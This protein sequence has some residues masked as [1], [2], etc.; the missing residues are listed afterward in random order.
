[1]NSTKYLTAASGAFLLVAI[2]FSAN[3][4]FAQEQ[5]VTTATP[6]IESADSV[7]PEVSETSTEVSRDE[8]PA[9]TESENAAKVA[10]LEKTE[11]PAREQSA[12]VLD[13]G[14][15]VRFGKR[16]SVGAKDDA[17]V[18]TTRQVTDD[19]DWHFAFTPYLFAAGMSGTVGARGVTGDLD[20]S[21]GDI[22]KSL[23]IGLMGTLEARRKKIVF[24]NDLLW[25]KLSKKFDGPLNLYDEVK[26]GSNVFMWNPMV[27]Y[28]VYEG[29]AGSFDVLGGIRLMSLENNLDFRNGG[30]LPD[31]SVSSRKT[32]ATPV[33][34]GRGLLNLSPKF[35]LSTEF[36]LGGGLGADFTGQFYGGVGY[37]VKPKIALVGGYRYLK[38]NY[39]D[40]NGFIFDT[41]M[42][43][44]LFGAR[45]DF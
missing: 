7:K 8:I 10:L 9:K 19:K 35:F 42:S 21:F 32:F 40:D 6:Q 36:D 31:I 39:D 13:Y 16:I 43:G 5:E 38:T 37:R 22:F 33:G 29:K 18:G 24:L 4:V 15:D 23:D 11:L 25:I 27:G 26:L 2:L 34:G 17:P 14:K 28:R 3:S 41:S 44:L 20:L 45:F 12:V 30:L 1:M